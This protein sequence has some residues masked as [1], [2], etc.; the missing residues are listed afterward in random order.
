VNRRLAGDFRRD[1]NG[2]L[3]KEAP[4]VG[5]SYTWSNER[6]MPMLDRIDRWFSSVDWELAHPDNLLTAMYSSISD[7]VPL[8]MVTRCDISVKPRFRFEAFWAKLLGFVEVVDSLWKSCG[9]PLG[10]KASNPLAVLDHKLRATLWVSGAGASVP[11]ETSSSNWLWPM[12]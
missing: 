3:I 4:L 10:P 5:K 2:L 7:H 6:A 11:W 1:I 9:R 8:L 12:R